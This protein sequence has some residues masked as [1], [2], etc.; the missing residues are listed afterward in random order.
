MAKS[1]GEIFRKLRKEQKIT[2]KA[3]SRGLCVMSTLSRIETGEREPDQLLFDSLMSRLGKESNQWDL[4]LKENDR[5]LLQKR[6]RI[7][8]FWEE[9]EWEKVKQELE[10]YN[11]FDDV[12]VHL[13]EQYIFFIRAVLYKQEQKYEEALQSCYKGLER[14]NFSIDN[15]KSEY[16]KIEE[17][18]SRN[19]LQ[20][21]CLIGECC[22]YYKETTKPLNLYQYW[23]EILNYV[24]Q[25][26][27][28][29]E[30]YFPFLIQAYFYLA[31]ITYEQEKEIESIYYI[32]K[33]MEKNR[34]KK[35]ICYLYS[36]LQLIKKINK[37]NIIKIDNM[38]KEEIN[39]LLETIK[40]WKK[41]N[42]KIKEK[43]NYIRPINNVYSI[44]EI[45]KY[46]RYKSKKTQEQMIGVDLEGKNIGDQAGLSEIENGKRNPRKTTVQHYFKQLGIQEVEESF[47][48]TIKTEDFEL[49]EFKEKV[50]FYI[51]I[52]DF[53]KAKKLLNILKGK[54][55]RSNPYNEQYIR[56]IEQYMKLRLE[57][58]PCE[59]WKKEIS[60]IL[61]LTLGDISDKKIEEFAFLTKEELLLF[62]NIGVGYHVNGEYKQALEYYEGIENS[63]FRIYPT[64]SS[65]I[66]KVLLH[67]LSQ[68]YGL[69]GRYEESMDKSRK[70]IFLEIA[71]KKATRWYR[72]LYNIGWCYGKMMLEEVESIKKQKYQ[73]LCK[74]YFRQAY[75]LAKFYQDEV[76]TN[77]IIEKRNIWKI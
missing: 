70:C 16:F 10:G 15:V 52:Q 61:S 17:R 46:A 69:I 65:D 43:E 41:E 66:Y 68:V 22:F 48:L 20:L 44:N 4:L 5:R 57:K 67:N 64:A 37:N 23:K 38:E 62:M 35:S 71:N 26:C 33:G 58:I 14:T 28:D 73:M 25:N 75:E 12:T 27:T 49:Q 1:L 9:E 18:V 47:I 13:Q 21:L 76:I 24:V 45:I 72:C 2:Q 55:D 40:E 54:M 29:E 42:K 11:K 19:E 6:N 63:F 56:A 34:E 7:E 31:Y 51:A 60:D 32:Q 50:D 53:E 36:F 77:A 8:Y 39:I 74:K 3:L 30:Y 59:I